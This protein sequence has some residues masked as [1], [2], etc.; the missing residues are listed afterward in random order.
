MRYLNT[1][2][3]GRDDTYGHRRR[4]CGSSVPQ[5]LGS[6]KDLSS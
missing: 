6:R 1:E 2:S 5:N 4:F 3:A